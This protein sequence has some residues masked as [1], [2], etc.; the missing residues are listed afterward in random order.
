MNNSQIKSYAKKQS[1]NS[2]IAKKFSIYIIALIL[3]I[4]I[5]LNISYNS[6]KDT[7]TS[8]FEHSIKFT[9]KI[10]GESIKNASII[11]YYS[12]IE[13]LFDILTDEQDIVY[14][15]MLSD[16]NTVIEST[17][18]S[19]IGKN[20]NN[21]G[22]KFSREASSDKEIT[23]RKY[24]DPYIKEQLINDKRNIINQ[25][26]NLRKNY[27]DMNLIYNYYQVEE[28]L[29][30]LWK[31]E[32]F[33][34]D[35]LYDLY[36]KENI[37]QR[38]RKKIIKEEIKN[39]NLEIDALKKHINAL[40]E[41]GAMQKKLEKKILLIDKIDQSN[42][43]YEVNVPMLD[44]D[45]EKYGMLRIGFSPKRGE[46]I[47][48]QIYFQSM[49]VGVLFIIVGLII[50]LFLASLIT[51]P[52]QKLLKGAEILGRGELNYRI[53]MKTED[54]LELLANSLN[55]MAEK[56]NES[57][58]S[59][60]QKVETRTKELQ[61]AYMKLQLTQTQ[62]VH[63]EKMTSLGQ[64]VAGVAHELNN[65][66]N[67]ITSNVKPLENS[68]KTLRKCI[69]IYDLFNITI[70]EKTHLEEFKIQ[71][72]F[73]FIIKDLDY[74]IEDIKEGASRAQKIIMDLRNFSRLDEAEYK[75]V[76]ILQGIKSTLNLAI[77]Q[78]KK[79]V[80]VHKDFEELPLINCYASQLNQVWMNLLI[81]ACQAIDNTGDIWLRA[82][83][84]NEM[85]VVEIKDNGRG[86]EKEK[87]EKI[88]DPF[89]TTKPVGQGTGLG[90]S[91]THSIIQKHNGIILVE[92][93]IGQG[94]KFTVKLPINKD[95]HDLS[96]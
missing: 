64:L 88:F 49:F 76:D 67:F 31:K 79:R 29:K 48:K 82:Y 14:A 77:N 32:K 59:L 22:D 9:S 25:M 6:Q 74:L 21:I 44:E 56:L 34:K 2:S 73:D 58:S 40:V 8:N 5:F 33:L 50:S 53:N 36:S 70:D 37:S 57:Y 85:I 89:F 81:N 54:E 20:V 71:N 72:D 47:I 91:I 28:N 66:I 90:L 24:K 78:Y 94:S 17:I 12:F 19:Y 16:D 55:N 27:P 92:S 68:L 7:F 41:L 1:L 83:K 86:I 39:K 23:L 11:R 35:K 18:E 69:E 65:P 75:E 63:S 4:I 43:I 61:E 60:E 52:I 95:N 45:S 15:I 13:P 84:E 38:L 62:L 93:T 26:H 96:D 51:V 46:T 30:I 87:L 80:V 3:I 10:I 42:L